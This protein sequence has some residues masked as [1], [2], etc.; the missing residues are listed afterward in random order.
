MFE[1]RFNCVR[2]LIRLP[3]DFNPKRVRQRRAIA[4]M[5]WRTP[6]GGQTVEEDGRISSVA[7]ELIS[8]S[9]MNFKEVVGSRED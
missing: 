7:T 5:P 4:I 2:E 8:E 6:K 9:Q 1:I 3:R